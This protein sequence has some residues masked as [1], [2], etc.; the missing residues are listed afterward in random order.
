MT[1]AR[2][3]TGPQVPHSS[4]LA[5]VFN[6]IGYAVLVVEAPVRALGSVGRFTWR[7][8]TSAF[9]WALELFDAHLDPDTRRKITR[10]AGT[11]F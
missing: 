11:P 5:L 9:S 7:A 8:F 6:A 10:A 1:T 4:I 3:T 2:V